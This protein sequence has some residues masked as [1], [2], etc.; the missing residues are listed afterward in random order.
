[1]TKTAKPHTRWER[2]PEHDRGDAPTR[3]ET[4]YHGWTIHSH[5]K[6]MFMVMLRFSTRQGARQYLMRKGKVM[7][8]DCRVFKCT[9]VCPA[10]DG[11]ANEWSSRKR[12][13]DG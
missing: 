3:N 7:G 11:E 9:G 1:M 2:N 4:H 13:A 10:G 12:T 8:R 5:G 6:G